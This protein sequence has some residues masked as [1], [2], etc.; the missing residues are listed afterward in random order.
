MCV[1]GPGGASPQKPSPTSLAQGSA[2]G[3]EARVPLFSLSLRTQPPL[4]I[5]Q[6]PAF[7]SWS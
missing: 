5:A 7:V 3:P 4:D 2:Q 6:L 1:Q